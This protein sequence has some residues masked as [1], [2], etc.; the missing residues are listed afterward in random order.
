MQPRLCSERYRKAANLMTRKGERIDGWRS[1]VAV[2]SE[3]AAAVGVAMHHVPA[4]HH[5]RR[6]F[7]HYNIGIR[8][9]NSGRFHPHI[10]VVGS[11]DARRFSR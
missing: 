3:D 8:D 9:G 1:V 2:L 11:E 4:V 5:K 10:F 7:T 6:A